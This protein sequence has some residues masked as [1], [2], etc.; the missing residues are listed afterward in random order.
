MRTATK[1]AIQ[2]IGPLV[3]GIMSSPAATAWAQAEPV[4]LKSVEDAIEYA[5]THNPE[6]GE[7]GLR[8]EQASRKY[9]ALRYHWLP[10]VYASGSLKINSELPVTPVPG[11]LFG[12][13]GQTVDVRFGQT[14]NYQAGIS[15][16]TTVLDIQTRFAVQAAKSAFHGA[17][18]NTGAFRQR[19]HE[20][21]AI[22]YY[23]T[24]ATRALLRGQQTSERE[25]DT[26]VRIVEMRQAQGIVDQVAV[27]RAQINKNAVRQDVANY[28][29]ILEQTV[30]NLKI[31]LGLSAA[32][33]LIFTEEVHRREPEP[34]VDTLGPDLTLR[35]DETYAEQTRFQSFEQQ[36]RWLPK[37]TVDSYLGGQHLRD[38]FGLSFGDGDWSQIRYVT[39]T[40]NFPLFTGFDRWNEIKAAEA[41]R[42]Q[43][44]LALER[45]RDESQAIDESLVR[46]R[47]IYRGQVSATRDSHELS[48]TNTTLA[49]RKYEQGVIGLE[50]YLVAREEQRGAEAAYLNALL[51]YYRLV[52]IYLSREGFSE[53]DG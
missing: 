11:E 38:D 10:R 3:A 28:L 16:S 7:Y 2:A 32:T 37:L 46:R 24:L 41:A 53:V 52:S 35:V 47:L 22:N 30:T 25:A 34:A 1:Y 39:L 6:L 27:N 4:T 14:Y 21:V 29:D 33:Q 8:E 9:E 50:E 17:A 45:R 13:P 48:R 18:A 26:L 23:T 51:T 42:A 44:E 43:A 36:S 49:L 5:Q 15:L 31:L 12:Q 40:L 19:L 20:E